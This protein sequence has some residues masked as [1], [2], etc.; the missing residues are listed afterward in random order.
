MSKEYQS[1]HSFRKND[2]TPPLGGITNRYVD[3][4][5]WTTV[6]NMLTQNLVPDTAA[7]F[8]GGGVMRWRNR[9]NIAAG[10][11]TDYCTSYRATPYTKTIYLNMLTAIGWKEV[12]STGDWSFVIGQ[13]D[14]AGVAHVMKFK[15][16]QWGTT[17]NAVQVWNATS[18]AYETVG[19]LTFTSVK[20]KQFISL[21]AKMNLE[22][23]YMTSLQ[24]GALFFDLSAYALET[25]I[26][27]VF[28]SGLVTPAYNIGI[29]GVE[30][31]QVP[32]SNNYDTYLDRVRTYRTVV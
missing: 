2:K 7:T 8:K 5:P 32:L 15:I 6:G 28:D 13:I 18:N 29:L 11:I 21:V 31:T 14:N 16:L 17:S 30:N 26:S 1:R 19:T 23:G 24:I 3:T 9:R 4:S 27:K 22:T 20:T 12:V 10:N 25:E